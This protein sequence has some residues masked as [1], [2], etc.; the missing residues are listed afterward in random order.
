MRE[1]ALVENVTTRDC[2]TRPP[3][4]H[5]PYIAV[6]CLTTFQ[7]FAEASQRVPEVAVSARLLPVLDIPENIIYV[8]HSRY[9]NEGPCLCRFDMMRI[10]YL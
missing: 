8:P 4:W 1:H 2:L 5:L 9:R 7:V 6:R 3:A 10:S